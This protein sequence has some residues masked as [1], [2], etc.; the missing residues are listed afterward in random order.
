MAYSSIN[1]PP[2]RIANP[3]GTPTPEFY[4][5]LV[6][7]DKQLGGALLDD[8]GLSAPSLQGALAQMVADAVSEALL[9]QS[10]PLQGMIAAAVQNALDEAVLAIPPHVSPP[11]EEPGLLAPPIIVQPLD[12]SLL[13]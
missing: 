2:V 13:L 9:A 5:W 7:A 3:D 10:A 12:E 1:P 6:Q 4:R 8:S 11:C